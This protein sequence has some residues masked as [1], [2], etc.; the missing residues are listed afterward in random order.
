LRF[1]AVVLELVLFLLGKLPV[2]FLYSKD[3]FEDVLLEFVPKTP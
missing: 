2:E 1:R 3:A